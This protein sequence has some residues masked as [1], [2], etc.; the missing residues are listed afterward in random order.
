M[1]ETLHRNSTASGLGAGGAPCTSK[2]TG[3]ERSAGRTFLGAGA[4]VGLVWLIYWPAL[5]GS[6]LWDDG[7]EGAHNSMLRHPA[8]LAKIWT[9]QGAL[10]YF[11]L[12]ATVQWILWRIWGANPTGWHAFS[13]A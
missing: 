2:K 13:I 4:I 3:L 7:Y 8:G 5:H 9:G 10:D 6:W 12:K 11:P 1:N